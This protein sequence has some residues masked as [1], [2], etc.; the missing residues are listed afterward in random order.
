MALGLEAFINQ[1]AR[2][3]HCAVLPEKGLVDRAVVKVTDYL[4]TIG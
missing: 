4:R 1:K 3:G 2:A